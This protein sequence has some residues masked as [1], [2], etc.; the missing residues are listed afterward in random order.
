MAAKPVSAVVVAQGPAD[1]LASVTTSYDN[2][3]CFYV[4][5]TKVTLESVDPETP[6][7]A[8]LRGIGL[9]GTKL[10]CAVGG[11]GVCTVV[12]L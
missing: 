2:V 11:C 4:N 6:L 10:G 3:L 12:S 8:Y 1:R 7:L 5:G 9:T